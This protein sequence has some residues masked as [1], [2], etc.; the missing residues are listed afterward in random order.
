M[1]VSKAYLLFLIPMFGIISC[2]NEKTHQEDPNPRILFSK[3]A[4][5]IIEYTSKIRMANDTA[6][7]DSLAMAYD[8]KLTEVN[9]S[10]PF[11]TDVKLTEQENDSL[12]KL[13]NNFVK[14][15]ATKMKEL[16][17]HNVTSPDTIANE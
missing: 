10:V 14:I 12:K 1:K 2:N 15:K 17:R 16:S 13:I 7:V 5:I 3:S 6:T 8:K 9:F 4:E 11:L